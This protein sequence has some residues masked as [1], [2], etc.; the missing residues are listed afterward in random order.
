MTDGTLQA[1]VPLADHHDVEAFASGAPTLDAW[2]RRKARANQA[3][4]AS[5]T[6]VLCRT[7]RV[8]GFYALAAGSV[9]H[10]LSPRKLRQNMP[11]PVPVIVLGRLA[12]DVREQGNGLGR[13][14]LRDAV[15]RVAAAA[16]EVGVGAMLV[17]A[18]N[19]RAK[20]FYVGAGFEPSPVDPM[21]LILRIKDINALL[22]E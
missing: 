5:R 18:L 21:V 15:L 9:S 14:L 3:S 13:A 2:I 8:V 1:P 12:V 22:C 4:G 20:A 6:Y 19:D 7:D 10:D 16:R 11:D 17:H